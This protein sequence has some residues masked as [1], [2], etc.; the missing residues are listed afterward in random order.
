MVVVEGTPA[1]V[2]AAA[3]APGVTNVQID[4]PATTQ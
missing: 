3:R 4:R 1:Q 2:A